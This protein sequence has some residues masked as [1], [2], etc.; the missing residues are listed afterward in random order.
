MIHPPQWR[1]LGRTKTTDMQVVRRLLR[2]EMDI[3]WLAMHDIRDGSRN[4]GASTRY[5]MYVAKIGSTPGFQTKIRDENGDT[6]VE[7][8]KDLEFIPNSQWDLLKSLTSESVEDRVKLDDNTRTYHNS[9]QWMHTVNNEMTEA[10]IHPCV[11]M[12]SR[13]DGTPTFRYSSKIMKDA[14]GKPIHFGTP[15]VIISVWQQSG[16]PLLDLEGKYGVTEHCACIY[17]DKENLPLIRDAMNGARFRSVMRSVQFN[18]DDWNKNVIKL[19]RKDFWKE[20]IDK[21]G[22]LIDEDGNVI[23]ETNSEDVRSSGKESKNVR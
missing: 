11:W 18:T 1:G 12:L 14:F 9:K 15:K 10:C 5:D 13:V 23:S 6:R 20:F 17:D 22:N 7:C 4:F 3:E 2:K 8:I 16:Q 19:F 21:D